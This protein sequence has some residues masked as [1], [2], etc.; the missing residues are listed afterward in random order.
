[1]LKSLKLKIFIFLNLTLLSFLFNPT[2][3]LAQ[4]NNV[5]PPN[6]PLE[7]PIFGFTQATTFADYIKNLYKYGLYILVPIAIVIIITAGIMWILSGGNLANIKQAKK[8]I[9][10]ALTGLIIGLLSYVMLSLVG[11]TEFKNLD[12]EYIAS[13]E[14]CS[15]P[16]DNYFLLT[17]ADCAS[18]EGTI[19]DMDECLSAGEEGDTDVPLNTSGINGVDV[20]FKGLIYCPKSGGQAILAQIGQSSLG[21]VT[22]RWGAK[23]GKP[24]Y[25]VQSPNIAGSRYEERKQKITY[26]PPGTICLDCSG[27]TNYLLN[28]AGLK[29][30]GGGTASIFGSGCSRG[31]RITSIDNTS[32]NGIPLKPGDALGK[33]SQHV[34]IYVGNG[35]L[36]ESAGGSG[37]DD[38]GGKASK[39]SQVMSHKFIG[40]CIRR[41]GT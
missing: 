22:Y 32:V 4:T 38:P 3:I 39:K 33:P 13:L 15:Y 1:M 25:T 11:I 9:T 28:C 16:G 26:C 23:G 30:F 36:F 2:K 37:W 20:N 17:K 35:I 5:A 14:C 41:Y 10:G 27:Y 7:V 8:Y 29:P 31:E 6:Y 21:K 40:S 34:R 24:P 12:L 19:K 18:K